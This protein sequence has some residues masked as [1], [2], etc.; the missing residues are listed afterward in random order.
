MALQILIL[1]FFLPGAASKS[2]PFPDDFGHTRHCDTCSG[3]GAAQCNSSDCQTRC[4]NE[5]KQCFKP[6]RFK[7]GCCCNPSEVPNPEIYKC[8]TGGT[9]SGDC[10]WECC[11]A[12]RYGE[13]KVWPVICGD[14]CCVPSDHGWP[15]QCGASWKLPLQGSAPTRH[16]CCL[17]KGATQDRQNGARCCLHGDGVDCSSPGQD[18]PCCLLP[19]TKVSHNK[20][21]SHD[22]HAV[23]Q[24]NSCVAYV[25]CAGTGRGV[26]CSSLDK[27]VCCLREGSP[28]AHDPCQLSVADCSTHYSPCRVTDQ[29]GIDCASHSGKSIC[30]LSEGKEAGSCRRSESECAAYHRQQT[31]MAVIAVVSSVAAIVLLLELCWRCYKRLRLCYRSFMDN[32]VSPL[33]LPSGDIASVSPLIDHPYRVLLAI[34]CEAYYDTAN[35]PR[36][37]TPHADADVLAQECQS[38]GYDEVLLVRASTR[39]DIDTGLRTAVQKV[40]GTTKALLMISYSGH[41]VEVDGRM[42]W[43]PE[44]ANHDDMGTHFDASCLC[45]DLMEVH[46]DDGIARF[47]ATQPAKNLFAVLLADCCRHPSVGNHCDPLRSILSR[48]RRGDR[49]GLYV[50]YSC[51]PGLRADDES[52]GG[53]SPF[54]QSVQEQL[55]LPQRVGVFADNVDAGLRRATGGRPAAFRAD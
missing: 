13:L 3:P 34:S 46:L 9:H 12:R 11:E 2:F 23:C 27:F 18:E 53:H 10:K 25:P 39:A 14:G 32:L 22:P 17:P 51:G 43:A 8:R 7:L 54:V 4:V 41:A 15:T 55:R 28:S 20:S 35:Y 40:A 29:Q 21:F 31:R 52:S 26:L 42:M 24:R 6:N 30:C 37:T 50:I 19:S 48:R 49:G 36:L 1:G 47:G 38:M 44:S 33:L 5:G 16:P 45:R